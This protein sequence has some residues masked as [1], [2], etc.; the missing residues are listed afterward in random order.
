[1]K[2]LT[3]TTQAR[4]ETQEIG[5]KMGKLA[6]PN[7]VFLLQGDLGAGKT[8]LTQGI[9]RGLGVKR[10]VTSPTFNLLKIYQGRM[11]LYHID[12]YRME[13]VHQDLGLDEFLDDNGLTVIEWSQFMPGLIPE[14]YL[15]VSIRLLEGDGRQMDFEAHGEAYEALLEELQ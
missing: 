3:I 10:T 15:R 7:M 11:P 8:T 14:T 1:M 9:A 5:Q 6:K 13:G 4:Q 12:A 2:T